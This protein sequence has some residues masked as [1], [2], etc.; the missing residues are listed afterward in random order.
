MLVEV[1]VEQDQLQLFQVDQV[2]RVVEEQ[3]EDQ[4]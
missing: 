4:V 2:D 3:A 1:E